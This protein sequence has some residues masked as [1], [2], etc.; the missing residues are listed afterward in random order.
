M[1]NKKILPLEKI[2]SSTFEDSFTRL[3]KTLK[4]KYACYVL[5]TCTSP[6]KDGKMEVEM[7]F[8]GEEDLAAFLVDNASQVFDSRM[9]RQESK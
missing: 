2:G 9:P 7:N 3:K 5:I 8:E 4:D 1:V 6:E